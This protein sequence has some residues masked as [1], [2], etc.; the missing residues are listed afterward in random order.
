[1]SVNDD[2]VEENEYAYIHEQ[3]LAEGIVLYTNNIAK[4]EGQRN[5]AKI[6]LK[7]YVT[8]GSK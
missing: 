5:F 6:K 4:Y 2:D 8:N 1:V 3:R 7:L